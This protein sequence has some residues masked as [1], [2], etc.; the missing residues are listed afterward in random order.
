M[1]LI[2]RTEAGFLPVLLGQS[3]ALVWLFF[4]RC[5]LF[6]GSVLLHVHF[7]LWG[8]GLIFLACGLLYPCFQGRGRPPGSWQGSR[9]MARGKILQPTNSL[10][11]SLLQ[12]GLYFSKLGTEV[13]EQKSASNSS[14][15]GEKQ[16]HELLD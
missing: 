15:A 11:N 14:E 5:L 7:C 8:A 13:L 9:R 4:P 1:L 3:G 12:K 6:L 10:V 16:D 2:L